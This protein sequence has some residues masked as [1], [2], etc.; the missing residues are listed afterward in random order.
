VSNLGILKCLNSVQLALDSS[1]K[2]NVFH[3]I[4]LILESSAL[5]F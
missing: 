2:Y 3:D 4:L 5:C 1:M